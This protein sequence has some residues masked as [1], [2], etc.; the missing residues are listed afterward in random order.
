M[1]RLKGEFGEGT[2]EALRDLHLGIKVGKR[3]ISATHSFEI[4]LS[5]IES[6]I[7][8][9]VNFDDQYSEAFIEFFEK[10]TYDIINMRDEL[11]EMEKGEVHI[12]LEEEAAEKLGT[13]WI[14]KHINK[15]EDDIESEIELEKELIEKIHQFIVKIKNY[16]IEAEHLFS[17]NIEK[18][19][20]KKIN[21]ESEENEDE[22]KHILKNL[23]LFVLFYE[24]IFEQTLNDLEEAEKN[25][26]SV[27]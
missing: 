14:L 19:I 20:I 7:M 5:I 17:M 4:K 18:S 25:L 10:I 21:I 9:H 3:I 11:E 22:V 13:K 23:L 15:V 8:N 1:I 6:S 16:F 2:K 27:L 12:V 24:K 26:K